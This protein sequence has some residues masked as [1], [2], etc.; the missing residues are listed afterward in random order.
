MFFILKYASP[1]KIDIWN[2]IYTGNKKSKINWMNDWSEK[3]KN[4]V[5][6]DLKI[7]W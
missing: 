7:G 1:I 5:Q 6:W 3:N 4:K 2:T